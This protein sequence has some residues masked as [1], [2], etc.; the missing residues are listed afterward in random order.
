MSRGNL[1]APLPP[2]ERLFFESVTARLIERLRQMQSSVEPINWAS[3]MS[4]SLMRE[5]EASTLDE[6]ADAYRVSKRKL[7]TKFRRTGR[8]MSPDV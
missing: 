7:A 6:L 8:R 2:T 5:R 3:L 4:A 1:E